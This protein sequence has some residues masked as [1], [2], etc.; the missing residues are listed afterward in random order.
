MARTKISSLSKGLYA[1]LL[2][3]AAALAGCNA[4]NGPTQTIVSPPPPLPQVTLTAAPTTSAIG[5]SSTLTWTT[6]N[7]TAC[8][9][10]GAWSGARATSGTASTG[11]FTSP[12]TYS[13]VL[14]CTGAGGSA[15]STATVMVGATA[16][17][18]VSIRVSPAS[19]APGGSSTISWSATNAT[20]CTAS[21]A[22]SGSRAASGSESTGAVATAGNYDYTL[23][24]SGAG[25]SGSNTATLTVSSTPAPTVTLTANPTQVANGGSSTL[26]WSSTNASA[27]SASGRWTGARTP[28]GRETVGPLTAT[29]LNSYT[30]TCSGTNNG[31]AA[32]TAT[33]AVGAVPPP[34][35]T[36]SVAPASIGA[37]DS[38]TLTWSSTD[39]SACTASGSWSGS[40]NTSGMASTG[41]LNTAGVYSYSLSCSGPSGSA[42]NSATLT[43]AGPPGFGNCP[44][45]VPASA[46]LAPAAQAT[47]TISSTCLSCTVDNADAVTDADVTGNFATIT[48][49]LN[50]NGNAALTVTNNARFPAGRRVGFVISKPGELLSLGLLQSVTISTLLGGTVQETGGTNRDGPVLLDL[51]LLLSSPNLSVFTFTTTKDFDAIQI[52]DGNLLGVLPQ[53]NVYLACVSR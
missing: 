24:C 28:S 12:G 14:T 44:I 51:L 48:T 15:S 5:G 18:V 17:P 26:T 9:A 20:A 33:V 40:Q 1:L 23:T 7:A 34:T 31:S 8:T 19:I 50:V 45:G 25:G 6:S 36:I 37:G 21:G 10:S 16:A 30:L 13:Y 53:L 43:V 39:A 32:A 41:A 29:G 46:L 3:A 38:A 11:A 2:G 52:N 27:C 4:D 22:W 47:S 49:S 35:V 42:A